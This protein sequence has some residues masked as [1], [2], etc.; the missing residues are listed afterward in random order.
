[1]Q[2]AAADGLGRDAA[3]RPSLTAKVY[4]ELKLLD[5]AGAGRGWRN[6]RWRQPERQQ[7]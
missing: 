6:C 7:C 5:V 2:V 3:Q 1:M 4:K